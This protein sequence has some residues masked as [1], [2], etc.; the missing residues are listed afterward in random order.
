MSTTEQE[1]VTNQR[2]ERAVAVRRLETTI[3]AGDGRTVSFRIAPFGEIATCADGLGGLPKGVPYQEQ[4][5][6]GLY[7]HQVRAAH[8]VFLNFEHQQGVAGI[9][10]HGIELRKERDGYHASFRVHENRDGDTTLELVREGVLRGASVESYWLKSTRAASGVVQR[11]KAHLEAVAVCREGAYPSAVLTGMRAE[12]IPEEIVL[13][14][15]LLPVNPDP[16]LLARCRALGI[17]VPQRFEAHPAETD[18][19]AES[20]TS[21]D[22][23]RPPEAKADPE[24]PDEHHAE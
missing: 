19:P 4:L 23:T 7:D 1:T 22:G 24:V 16:D 10:G 6:P 14:E 5:M 2:P 20:G 8:R 13:D 18:T 3:A 15:E 11:V 21:E 12:E 17:R 9:V